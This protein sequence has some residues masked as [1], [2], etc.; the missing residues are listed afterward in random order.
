VFG[1]KSRRPGAAFA[2]QRRLFE[3]K[4]PAVIF[5]VGAHHG[6]T[7]C[8]YRRL[9]P[10]ATIYSFEPFAESFAVLERSAAE[11]GNVHAI[12]AALSDG[13]GEAEFHS[14]VGT[15]TNSLLPI[16][17]GADEAWPGLMRP[18]ERVRVATT[19]LDA[20][21]ESRSIGAIDLLKLDVQAGEPRV[22]RGGERMLRRGA[23]GLVFTEIITAPSYDGQ[24]ELHEFLKMM[25]DYEFELHNFYHPSVT[26]AGRL[27]SMDAIFVPARARMDR[28]SA[29][30]A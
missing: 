22:F 30:A 23:V 28:L 26:E 1:L 2:A 14:N 17:P 18:K 27:R 6:E 16:A 29:R 25:R 12:N 13:I 24:I 4:P 9:F 15:G 19:T 5:D 3:G 20:F 8:E 21:C 10:R 11:L 7:A